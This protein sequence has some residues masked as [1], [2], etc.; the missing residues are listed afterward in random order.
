MIK[1]S[2][3]ILLLLVTV[4]GALSQPVLSGH[5]S[6][7]LSFS[8]TSLKLIFALIPNSQGGYD[9]R[10]AVPAQMPGSIP[11]DQLTVQADSLLIYIKNINGTYAGKLDPDR[12]RTTGIWRQNGM[13][14]SLDLVRIDTITAVK[15]SARP[16]TPKPP[17]P[18]VS[19]E[20]SYDHALTRSSAH[21]SGTLTKPTGRGPFPVALLITGSG[22]QDRDETL[23]DHKP[24]AVLADYLT[25]RGIAVLRVDDRGTGS[26][27]GGMDSLTSA[28]FALDVVAGIDYLKTRSDI[29]PKKIGLIGHSEGGMIAPMAAAERPD[30]VAFIVMLAAPGMPGVDLLAVQNTAMLESSGVDSKVAG[31][32]GFLYR[33]MGKAAI[34]FPDSAKAYQT[35][36][37]A[38]ATWRS[39]APP[40]TVTELTGAKDDKSTLQ[41]VDMLMEA[42]RSPWMNFL[43][44]YEPAANIGKLRCPV[45]ALNGEKDIQVDAALNLA[46][47]DRAVKADN[48]RVTTQ[49]MPGL[50]HLFQH[51]KTCTVAEYA[52]LTETFAPEALQVIGDWLV[53]D[54]LR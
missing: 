24:F 48:K 45:L 20:I 41:F 39:T 19:E 7:S 21:L 47:I 50:N 34:E 52:E 23:F 46:G 6:G 8:G 16:Q 25:R 9:A 3:S 10:L 33:A 17:F 36:T 37:A 22:Q 54:G 32:Y 38:F 51:C 4:T 30:D 5:W 18:Y 31:S 40:A 29:N 1:S 28:D 35:A 15:P 26:S 49:V 44:A 12:T 43:L 13:S 42:F 53:F 14:S 11:C 27:S 2:L